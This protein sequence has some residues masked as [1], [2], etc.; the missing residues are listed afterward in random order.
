MTLTA[1]E[2]HTNIQYTVQTSIAVSGFH[3]KL[4]GSGSFIFILNCILLLKIVCIHN[5]I[6]HLKLISSGSVYW[7]HVTY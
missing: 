7:C 6:F 5:L 3:A 2:H 1:T 4:A